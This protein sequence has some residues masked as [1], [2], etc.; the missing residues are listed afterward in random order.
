MT[1]KKYCTVKK[2]SVATKV[3]PQYCFIM[4]ML[5]YGV[6]S[7]VFSYQLRL[8]TDLKRM[9]AD[10]QSA[11]HL[12]HSVT[13]PRSDEIL[14]TY[15]GEIELVGLD[16]FLAETSPWIELVQAGYDSI[17]LR[18]RPQ[19]LMTEVDSAHTVSVNF[20]QERSLVKKADFV[21]ERV[22][23]RDVSFPLTE[24]RLHLGLGERQEA[25]DIY[26]ALKKSEPNNPDVFHTSADANVQVRRLR[27]ALHEI[28]RAHRLSP[29]NENIVQ[30]MDAME[31]AY[32]PIVYLGYQY[33]YGGNSLSQ[34]SGKLT[35]EAWVRRHWRLGAQ[36][37]H[38]LALAKDVQFVNGE[39]KNIVA[40]NLYGMLYVTH[41]F[42]QGNELTAE[43][44]GALN[45]MGAG[46]NYNFWEDNGFTG[47][48]GEL[49]RPF[50]SLIPLLAQFGARDRLQLQQEYRHKNIF[51]INVDPGL[52]RY[53]LP[54]SLYLA[55]SFSG[56]LIFR[57][58]IPRSFTHSILGHDSQLNASYTYT[59]E[60]PYSVATG[61]RDSSN[62][63]ESYQL[64]PLVD[65]ETHE[66]GA[67]VEKS[68]EQGRWI[69]EGYAGVGYS[70]YSNSWGV[71]ARA[72]GF[73]SPNQCFQTGLVAKTDLAT[74][75]TSVNSYVFEAFARLH[76]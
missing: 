2:N 39:L 7:P 52:N 58:F 49:N 6:C 11:D 60:Y 75:Q 4:V 72:A 61:H 18:S 14:L 32:A 44:Y 33:L 22:V 13:R 47:I 23:L 70:R 50:F 16:K 36:V 34:Y 37:E 69:V 74:Q 24:A 15:D 64:L 8:S 55:S 12:A 63:R 10:I 40:N 73:Y 20:I 9:M 31:C 67:G 30:A 21:S 19:Y 71:V 29:T 38:G 53:S 68:W 28:C 59:A 26:D 5:V 3:R 51:Q 1:P 27:L 48:R 62:G 46:A 65:F 76:Y 17:M 57:Y 42:P 41:Q 25:L 56:T 43:I 35:G 66:I 54:A 45:Y